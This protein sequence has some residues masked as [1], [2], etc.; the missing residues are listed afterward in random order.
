MTMKHNWGVSIDGIKGFWNEMSGG[1]ATAAV[2][3]DWGGGGAKKPRK[4][5]GPITHDDI[6]LTRVFYAATDSGW[7]AS[8]RSQMYS[9]KLFTVRKQ[10]LDGNGLKIGKPTVY[11]N[12]ILS[13]LTEP[14]TEGGS[15]D[16]AVVE[17]VFSHTGPA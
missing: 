8:L 4:S 5:G 12:C 11:Y 6:T 17:V 16:N 1:S 10:A 3:V 2:G 14:E 13:G 15:E 7:L 9:G